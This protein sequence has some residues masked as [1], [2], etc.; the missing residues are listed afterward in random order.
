M[1]VAAEGLTKVDVIDDAFGVLLLQLHLVNLQVLVS[2]TMEH[3][4]SCVQ[5]FHSHISVSLD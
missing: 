1:N 3:M 2:I 5:S 4:L